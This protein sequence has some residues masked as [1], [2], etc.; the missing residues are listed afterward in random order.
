MERK[1]EGAQIPS[2]SGFR[3]SNGSYKIDRESFLNAVKKVQSLSDTKLMMVLKVGR[4]T[5]HRFKKRNPKIVKEA[6]E[7]LDSLTELDMTPKLMIK[8]NF[9]NL[10]TIK[11]LKEINNRR[12][13]S[14]AKVNKKLSA[15]YHMCKYLN[16]HPKRASP[17]QVAKVVV[18]M[19]D[20]KIKGEKVPLGLSYLSQ[21]EAWRDYFQSINGISG[22]IL[23]DLGMDAKPSLGFGRYSR[24][25]LSPSQRRDFDDALKE[26]CKERGLKYNH[27]LELIAD[28]KCMFYS[29][30]RRSAMVEYNFAVN[31]HELTKSQWILFVIDKGKDDIALK[32]GQFDRGKEWEKTFVGDALK[33]LKDY[34][35]ERFKMNEDTL[36]IEIPK[37]I[38]WLFPLFH[39][40][41][42]MVTDIYKR[43]HKK[44]G[45]TTPIPV[46]IFRHTFAQ[47]C[48]DATDWNY[49]MVAANGGWETTTM[50][51][52]AY[53]EMGRGPRIRGLRKAMGLP[54]EDV[55]YELR[56]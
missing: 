1:D 19:R 50:L 47:D 28:A 4:S 10:P 9:L 36:E 13:V 25:R 39:D 20:R 21:R 3:A 29:G 33:V 56:W 40:Q 45:I 54:V 42:D 23:T 18:E 55:T 27:Y 5:V 7:Y 35:V 24:E 12:R 31:R 34:F 6:K 46:H 8:E 26:V 14:I 38:T 2:D 51:K 49:E 48:L 16:V 43:A 53:G 41:A 30:T 52:K 11:E 15:L 32:S 17:E 37:K 44:A 22:K